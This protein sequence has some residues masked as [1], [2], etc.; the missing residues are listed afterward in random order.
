MRISFITLSKTDAFLCVMDKSRMLP[1]LVFSPIAV[2]RQ[3]SCAKVTKWVRYEDEA[4]TM[5]L[6]ACH[7]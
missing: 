7:C 1:R 4:A 5:D 6:V 3:V 2:L